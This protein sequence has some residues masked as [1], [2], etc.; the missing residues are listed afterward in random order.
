MLNE[1]YLVPCATSIIPGNNWLVIAPHQDDELIGMGGTILKHRSKLQNI[2]IVYVTDGSKGGK[3][4]IRN[5]EAVTV[6]G[7]LNAKPIFLEFGDRSLPAK[8]LK[9]A[10]LAQIEQ[11]KPDTVF[12][13][14][15]LDYHPD[16]REIT[17]CVWDIAK[18]ST[19]IFNLI[20]Y[21]I[22][23][24]GMSNILVNITDEIEEKQN[25]ISIY[26]SQLLNQPYAEYSQIGNRL[27][28]LTLGPD[29]RFAESFYQ[30][31]NV[32][33]DI[34]NAVT[35]YFN[36]FTFGATDA[37]YVEVTLFFIIN[38]K[39]EINKNSTLESLSRLNYPNLNLQILSQNAQNI[40]TDWLLSKFNRIDKID[41]MP[42][43]SCY[44]ILNQ[45]LENI[46]S[47]YCLFLKDD[48][49]IET[50]HIKTLA[51]DANNHES[52]KLYC[53]NKPSTQFNITNDV[54]IP[55]FYYDQILP[56]FTLLIPRR[57]YS[58]IK[59]DTQLPNAAE[60]DYCLQLIQSNQ[61][62]FIEQNGALDE[63][64]K[65]Q[66]TQ[67]I[68]SRLQIKWLSTLANLVLNKFDNSS[69]LLE[70]CNLCVNL[71]QIKASIQICE[72][73]K[74]TKITDEV[75]DE[76]LAQLKPRLN[77]NLQHTKNN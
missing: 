27:R 10:I 61:F 70:L 55:D 68:K 51:K 11:H 47:D 13:P 30:F 76:L 20:S 5:A 22:S 74:N 33:G 67:S 48:D 54:N 16:H 42:S 65:T 36:N 9:L 32:S 31:E 75:C 46:E 23:N 58:V 56:L 35:Q 57:I 1:K 66:L 29:I 64:N 72:Y 18:E 39:N 40:D 26:E 34:A 73:A 3:E 24:Q 12:V 63:K 2:T 4:A 50:D 25:L 28:S 49:P 60:W 52:H 53:S 71:D 41:I 15:P 45:Q 44:T 21:E 69:A 8:E 19:T 77:D 7:H 6:C 14:S 37:N 38:T 59:F 43:E 17:A 62:H